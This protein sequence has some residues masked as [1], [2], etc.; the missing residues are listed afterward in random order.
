MEADPRT[1]RPGLKEERAERDARPANRRAH[2]ERR[3]STGAGT[4]AKMIRRAF[5][6]V[7]GATGAGKTTLIEHLLRFELRTLIA[8]R[9]IR[10]DALGEPREM[11]PRDR[12]ELKRYRGAGAAGVAEYRF[13][14]SH[15]DLD[16][17]YSTR[18]MG[19][20]SE[21]VLLEGD[22]PVEY[23]DL[24]VF[25]TSVDPRSPGLFRRATRDRAKEKLESLERFEKLL[26]SPEGTKALVTQYLG[27]TLGEHMCSPGRLEETH[28]SMIAIL[29]R[30][31]VA[32]APEPTKHWAIAPA[33]TGIEHA[34][35]VVVNIRSDKERL[36]AQ[37]LVEDLA[38]LRQD[39]AIFNDILGWRGHRIPITA[40]MA[41]LT[42]SRDPGLKKML[43]RIGRAFKQS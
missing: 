7:A 34:Q 31:H 21:G 2:P 19:D 18:F 16:A 11:A 6:L 33:Y 37:R 42:D 39:K 20:Y 35:A 4:A 40:V 23:V 29:E 8:A 9:C 13:P 36:G 10:D 1:L 43:A 41:N 15:A 24:K 30:E 38:R 25:V 26:A 27:K 28:A 12:S 5:I 22:Q 32:P 17:F 14:S 3:S